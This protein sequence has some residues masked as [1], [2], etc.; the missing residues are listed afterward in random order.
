MCSRT[1]LDPEKRKTEILKAALDVFRKK[2]FICSTME[3]IVKA[4]S[5][6][7]G[8]VYYYY[9]NTVDILHDLMQAGRKYRSRIVKEALRTAKKTK[10]KDF[11]AE[12]MV[13]KILSTNPYMDTYVEFLLNKKDNEKLENLFKDLQ[14]E[15]REDFFLI[16]GKEEK[17]F[18]IDELYDLITYVLNSFII[19]ANVLKAR[20]SF[21]KN[22]KLLVSLM[23]DMLEKL[24]EEPAN[25]CE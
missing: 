25:R 4:T 10:E 5:L 17:Y 14:E 11:I 8:G 12:Q 9:K 18:A 23:K 2:G 19:G 22:R 20:E 24:D 13:E 15:T 21:V 3:D 6:S 16:I 7:K 1:R